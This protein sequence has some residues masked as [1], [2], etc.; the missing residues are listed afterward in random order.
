M[1]SAWPSIV[2]TFIC[3][4]PQCTMVEASS[5]TK[6][7]RSEA[8]FTHLTL[9][10]VGICGLLH[11]LPIWFWGSTLSFFCRGPSNWRAGTGKPCSP[12]GLFWL[13]P[14]SWS[15]SQEAARS[16]TWLSSI[17]VGSTPPSR[18]SGWV[19]GKHK[20]YLPPWLGLSINPF[21][22]KGKQI[23]NAL[24]LMHVPIPLQMHSEIGRFFRHTL[25]LTPY[26]SPKP[27]CHIHL[28]N[29]CS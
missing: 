24:Y 9:N 8:V 15:C 6:G 10:S 23:V 1:T 5:M 16:T 4:L 11:C 2:K 3:V 14:L 19:I 17:I 13:G 18:S 20:A 22:W 27:S 26:Q 29:R 28:P 12:S 7:M 25:G 21:K